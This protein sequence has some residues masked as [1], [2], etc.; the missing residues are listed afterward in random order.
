MKGFAPGLKDG[1]VVEPGTLIGYVGATG[2]VSGPHLDYQVWKDGVN[3]NPADYG[4][5]T[6]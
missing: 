6:K 3:V 5:L 2:Q 1:Q 4:A